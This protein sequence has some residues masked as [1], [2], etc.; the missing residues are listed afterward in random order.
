VSERIR[1]LAVKAFEVLDCKGMARVDFFYAN[2]GRVLLNEI[3]TIPGFTNISMF[4][5]LWDAS[6]VSYEALVDRLIQ[7]ALERQETLN[8]LKYDFTGVSGGVNT[9]IPQN[10]QDGADICGP[11]H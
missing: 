4:P 10:K 3:N 7:L 5:M 8:A 1:E 6:G 2:D 9:A 11:G